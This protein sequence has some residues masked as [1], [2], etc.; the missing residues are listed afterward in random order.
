MSSS[1]RNTRVLVRKMVTAMIS[2]NREEKDA[3]KKKFPDAH[4]VRTMRQDSKRQNY[5]ATLEKRVAEK[6][7]EM[8][9]ITL[10]EVYRSED[11]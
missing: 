11:R 10:N 6:L 9:G 7:A 8:R 3:I 5:W 1:T 2:V 4:V